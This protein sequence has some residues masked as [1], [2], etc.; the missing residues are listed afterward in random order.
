MKLTRLD[1][2]ERLPLPPRS[3]QVANSAR[4][5]LRL[6]LDVAPPTSSMH[7]LPTGSRSS[8]I[9]S[10]SS[11]TSLCR[12][13]WVVLLP[14]SAVLQFAHKHERSWERAGESKRAPEP[15]GC[16]GTF[17]APPLLSDYKPRSPVHQ[18]KWPLSAV[19]SCVSRAS[20]F[21]S[22]FEA[23]LEVQAPIAWVVRKRMRSPG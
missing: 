7:S 2:N 21:E 4:V 12:A 13:C 19:P 17:R 11:E 20:P 10:P 3:L 9:D 14:R 23:K 6:R 8:A 15:P 5:T 18:T 16:R 22:P 1:D